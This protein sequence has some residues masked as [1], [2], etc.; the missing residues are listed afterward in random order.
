MR[1]E[2]AT[3]LTWPLCGQHGCMGKLEWDGWET[4]AAGDESSSRP[5][6]VDKGGGVFV[7]L[8]AYPKD[9]WLL[10]DAAACCSACPEQRSSTQHSA[11]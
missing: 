7:A 8:A 6:A 3:Y 1:V 11:A 10:L 2:R 4:R 5:N 9:T